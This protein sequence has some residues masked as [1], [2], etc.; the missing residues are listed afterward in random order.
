M[1]YS[2]IPS[3][4][5]YETREEFMDLAASKA[6]DGM[7]FVELGVFLGGTIYRMAHK[8]KERGKQVEICAVDNWQYGNIS[9]ASYSWINTFSEEY[10]KTIGKVRDGGSGYK[11]F[12]EAG[13]ILKLNVN[14]I[15][16]E[17]KDAAVK[18][19]D[20]SIDYIFFDACHGYGGVKAE[21]EAWLPKLKDKAMA[22]IH[23]YGGG[24]QQA[25]EEVLDHAIPTTSNGATG[26]IR[27]TL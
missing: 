26:I 11:A 13:K 6:E 4:V 16:S 5:D 3:L 8:I 18:F 22:G 1:K 15:V 9:G 21:L 12:V 24:I 7:V 19:S 2:D 25:T 14:H 23:D 27:N 20:K 10:T 17:T